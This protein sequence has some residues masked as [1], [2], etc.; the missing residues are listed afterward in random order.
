M[1]ERQRDNRRDPP[2]ATPVTAEDV[3]REHEQ[4]L[5]SLNEAQRHSLWRQGH[6]RQM[7]NFNG[8]SERQNLTAIFERE[9]RERN[10]RLDDDSDEP[11][12]NDNTPS[13][14]PSSE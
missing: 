7:M 5:A 3:R 8:L 6:A 12:A 14:E 4:A 1:S 13:A 2:N 9:A 10:A 11:Q